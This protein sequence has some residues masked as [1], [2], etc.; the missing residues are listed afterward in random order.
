[1]PAAP[2]KP[3]RA[4]A[5]DLPILAIALAG[6]AVSG[7]LTWIKW[8]GTGALFCTA[9]S[10]CDIVQAS[11][12]AIFLGVP[13]ALWGALAYLAVAILAGLGLDGRKWRAA[14][15][16]AAGAVGFSAYLT[17]L[18]VTELGAACVY[19]L[20]SAVLSVLLLVVLI[21]RRPRVAR[22]AR[23]MPLAVL[24]GGAAVAAVVLGAFVFAAGPEGA[25]PYQLTLARHLA[26]TGAVFYGAFWCPHCQEQK[27]KFGGAA[28]LLPYVECDPKGTNS[29]TERCERA[30]VRSFPTWEIAGSRREGVQSLEALAEASSF[31]K[32]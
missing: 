10:G 30:A 15:V 23:G 16:L 26:Q 9:G 27:H 8:S 19:C 4:V 20:V 18:S 28:G 6:F 5:P 17:F 1:M 13:T 2:G 31:P 7:Y 25:T 14:L 29:Q 22:G 3:D 24:G 32:N 12:Y 11:R 21:L